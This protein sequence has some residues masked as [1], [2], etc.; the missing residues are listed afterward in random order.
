MLL[1][2]WKIRLHDFPHLLLLHLKTTMYEKISH[3][4]NLLPRYI[5]MRIPKLVRN[6]IGCL[7]NNHDIIDHSMVSHSVDND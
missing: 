1:Q 4:H 7:T 2:L 3:T 5:R 6:H